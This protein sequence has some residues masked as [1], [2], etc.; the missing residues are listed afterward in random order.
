MGLSQSQHE[1]LGPI[2]SELKS[3]CR[4]SSNDAL[5]SASVEIE[6]SEIVVTFIKHIRLRIAAV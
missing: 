2:V 4:T 5:K 1:V 3:F 6:N